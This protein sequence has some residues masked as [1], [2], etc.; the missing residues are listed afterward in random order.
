MRRRAPYVAG[1]V[2]GDDAVV[3]LR[4]VELQ[5]A[6]LDQV[7]GELA[8]CCGTGYLGSREVQGPASVFRKL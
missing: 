1:V 7:I 6:L 2:E 4:L 3:I 8:D 5:L